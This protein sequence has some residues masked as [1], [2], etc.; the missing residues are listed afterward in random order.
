MPLDE[1]TEWFQPSNLEVTDLKVDNPA[2][3]VIPGDAHARL[4]IRFNDRQRGPE[5]VERVRGI[6]EDHA[7]GAR[8]EARISGEAFLNEPGPLSEIVT[9]AIPAETGLTPAPP[10]RRGPYAPRFPPK[11]CP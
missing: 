4:N 7:P 3:N 6:V 9:D 8:F 11:T 2:C 1:G 5:L 10:T